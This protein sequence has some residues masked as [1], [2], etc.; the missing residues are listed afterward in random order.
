MP[1]SA[2]E[3]RGMKFEYDYMKLSAISI[4]CATAILLGCLF[5]KY[6]INCKFIENGYIP[7]MVIGSQDSLWQK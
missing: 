7:K 2:R 5:Y 4:L 6:K 3:V 1:Q